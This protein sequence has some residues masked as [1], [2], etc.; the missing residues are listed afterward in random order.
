M[1]TEPIVR[2]SQRHGPP[3]RSGYPRP[4]HEGPS[5]LAS[6]A[7]DPLVPTPVAGDGRTRDDAIEVRRDV[8]ADPSYGR[9]GSN[10]RANGVIG[11]RLLN[12][13]G[14]GR[15]RR[16]PRPGRQPSGDDER[17]QHDRDRRSAETA[18][19]VDHGGQ[20]VADRTGGRSNLQAGGARRRP[21]G[22]ALQPGVARRP[23]RDRAARSAA[24]GWCRTTRSATGSGRIAGRSFTPGLGGSARRS[25]TGGARRFDAGRG[26]GRLWW[27]G[28]RVPRRRDQGV[29]AAFSHRPASVGSARTFDRD[30]PR[31]LRRQVRRTA[32]RRSSRARDLDDRR[33]CRALSRR[34]V[35]TSWGH[36]RASRPDSSRRVGALS[37][38]RPAPR[39]RGHESP[40]WRSQPRDWDGRTNRG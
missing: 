26:S 5:A 21:A 23:R 19:P 20:L 6:E 15:V 27:L 30:W 37:A 11:P 35:R 8:M 7:T 22:P 39:L 18:A 13:S 36:A 10:A 14:A 4:R 16:E 3:P 12:V 28:A 32:L 17:D 9:F 29:G 40:D 38:R 31:R 2:R 1:A 34:R 24:D 33:L 25:M